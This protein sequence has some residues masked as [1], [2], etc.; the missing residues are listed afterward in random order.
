[1]S[2]WWFIRYYLYMYYQAPEWWWNVLV[3]WF[4]WEHSIWRKQPSR[5]KEPSHQLFHLMAEKSLH[6]QRISS[7]NLKSISPEMK[8]TQIH[9]SQHV[10]RYVLLKNCIY[11]TLYE[12]VDSCD[13]PLHCNSDPPARAHRR[14]TEGA[15]V[16]H[17][18]EGPWNQ[19]QLYLHIREQH[20]IWSTYIQSVQFRNSPWQ[21]KETSDDVSWV[22]CCRLQFNKNVTS[23]T[24]SAE[25]TFKDAQ[26]KNMTSPTDDAI[27]R[28]LFCKCQS[29]VIVLEDLLRSRMYWNCWILKYTWK[30]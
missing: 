2:S 23:V 20:F 25:I 1:M 17:N 24:S 16:A 18:A 8:Q 5:P 11:L 3:W 10:S 9:S 15:G 19:V 13:N 26:L 21:A 14:E 29:N 28:I 6:L 30:T 22:H 27:W 12:G 7:E 4:V